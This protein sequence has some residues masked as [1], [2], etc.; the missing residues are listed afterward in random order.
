MEA[1]H[2]GCLVSAD[3]WALRWSCVLLPALPQLGRESLA[4]Y[5]LLEFP[6]IRSAIC[7]FLFS[8][9][10][11]E[12]CSIT[13]FPDVAHCVAVLDTNISF[14]NLWSAAQFVLDRAAMLRY[15]IF[16]FCFHVKWEIRIGVFKQARSTQSISPLGWL[17]DTFW[18]YAVISFTKLQLCIK[19][20]ETAP[21]SSQSVGPKDTSPASLQLW[22]QSRPI[23]GRLKQWSL[24]CWIGRSPYAC[25]VRE[26]GQDFFLPLLNSTQYCKP[27]P[28]QHRSVFALQ[29][30]PQGAQL[31][32]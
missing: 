7:S 8:C 14:S 21:V 25:L 1:L 16:L 10:N 5:N 29:E 11:N 12:N 22:R 28:L 30:P 6:L 24:A 26:L 31:V 32:L 19:T 27:L 2:R 13:F 18:Y 23:M 20:V 9:K 17:N 15:I 3:V 4:T